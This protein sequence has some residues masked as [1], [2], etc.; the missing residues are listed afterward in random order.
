MKDK[1]KK[2]FETINFIIIITTLILLFIFSVLITYNKTNVL[3]YS[4]Y[5]IGIGV[6]SVII[7]LI[8]KILN[9]KF[10]KFEFAIFGL[11]ILTLLSLIGTIDYDAA[12]WG[13]INR[14]EGLF[15]ILT[16]YV[17]ALTASN[18]KDKKQ[19][20]III[21]IILT[22]GFC[23]IIYGIFQTDL[24]TQNFLDIRN[25]KF[26]AMGFCGNSMFYGSL[27]SICY[28]VVLVLFIKEKSIKKN[29]F[30]GM[31]L[32][33]FTLGTLI[34]GSMA[35]ILADVIILSYC[36]IRN[37]LFLVKFKSRSYIIEIIKLILS[38]CIAIIFVFFIGTKTHHL[39]NDLKEM[40]E[41]MAQTITTGKMEDNFGTG[42]I[43]IWKNTI[44]KIKEHFWFGVGIDNFANA[45]EEPLLDKKPYGAVAVV[46]KAHNEYLQ[47]MFCE[48]FFTG[49]YY[50]IFMLTLGIKNIKTND[51]IYLSLLLGFSCYSIQAFFGISVTR[52]SPIFFIVVGLLM[53][54][55][56]TFLR[57][58][59]KIKNLY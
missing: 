32:C 6:V 12:L 48:G 1:I 11:I 42:R 7:Y 17:L 38:I 59:I 33:V 10:S 52:V 56:N 4:Y 13:I 23:N 8:N 40:K 49:V 31:L 44:P 3:I 22:I 18:I 45:F 14:R 53:G 2:I 24:V 51:K 9:F 43:Y 16:Y 20:K 39:G 34:S 25:K 41:Q 5:L 26:Y 29:I 30:Y 28:P 37:I 21:G 27:L 55:E 50:I 46:N 19:I 54:S 57:K 35:V 36:M 15:V 47:I 58:K